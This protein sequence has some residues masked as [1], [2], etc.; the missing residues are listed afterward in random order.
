M[1]TTEEKNGELVASAYLKYHKC[2]LHYIRF[3]IADCDE[4]EDLAQDVFVKLLECKAMLRENTIQHFVY[5]ITRNVTTDYLRRFY[6][7]KRE[8]GRIVLE[9]EKVVNTTEEKIYAEELLGLERRILSTFPH[10]RRTIYAL[11]V[12]GGK[13]A[14]EIAETLNLS[15][16]TVECHLFLGRRDMRRAIKACV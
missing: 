8:D 11:S 10:R 16:R 2:I 5:A 9:T 14:G 1:K 3:R 15:P 7:R 13:S 4:A 6:R 12:Y